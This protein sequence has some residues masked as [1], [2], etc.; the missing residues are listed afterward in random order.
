MTKTKK[1]LKTKTNPKSK[2]NILYN[3]NKIAITVMEVRADWINEEYEKHAGAH[4]Q[5]QHQQ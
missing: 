5:K 2:K 3:N 4:A 1:T